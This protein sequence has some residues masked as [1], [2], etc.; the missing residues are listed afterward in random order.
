MKCWAVKSLETG[1]Y[2]SS[3][4]TWIQMMSPYIDE[5]A[6]WAAADEMV[7]EEKGGARGNIAEVPECDLKLFRP[8][9][10]QVIPVTISWVE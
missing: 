7:V 9:R 2:L 4:S 5:D 10:T 6:A 1:L 3:Y 8:E